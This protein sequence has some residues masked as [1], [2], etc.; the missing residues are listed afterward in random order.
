MFTNPLPENEIKPG[1]K[2]FVLAPREPEMIS[3]DSVMEM[4]A[5]KA[6]MRG[7]KAKDRAE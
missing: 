1:D 3:R 5:E 2:V 6:R 4:Q 7:Y